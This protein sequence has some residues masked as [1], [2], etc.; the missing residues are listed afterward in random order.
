MRYYPSLKIIEFTPVEYALISIVVGLTIGSL[1]KILLIKLAPELAKKLTICPQK[2]KIL[3]PVQSTAENPTETNKNSSLPYFN[4][5]GG[6]QEPAYNDYIEIDMNEDFWL[7]VLEINKNSN[8]LRRIKKI[9]QISQRS[10]QVGK[11]S[12]MVYFLI[13]KI[14]E[15][16]GADKAI[17]L[18][19]QKTRQ[20]VSNYLKLYSEKKVI[21]KSKKELISKIRQILQHHLS[22]KQVVGMTPALFA[23][24]LELDTNYIN[25]AAWRQFRSNLIS[26]VM[27]TTVA[28]QRLSILSIGIA[29][30]TYGGNLRL[31][32]HAL[33]ASSVL[34]LVFQTL[35]HTEICT[36]NF[37]PI[38]PRSIEQI[39]LK[40]ESILTTAY[41]IENTPLIF[42]NRE[43]DQ[44]SP[45]LALALASDKEKPAIITKEKISNTLAKSYTYL[46][47]DKLESPEITV[48]GLNWY[49]NKLATLDYTNCNALETIIS[50]YE[51]IQFQD[52]EL[53]VLKESI[54]KCRKLFQ[55]TK[56]GEQKKSQEII[57]KQ[58]FD[59]TSNR[60]PRVL[61]QRKFNRQV[62]TLND[63]SSEN[64]KAVNFAEIKNIPDQE[65]QLKE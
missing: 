7:K 34:L 16:P 21:I 61:K 46:S 64:P 13:E 8:V 37:L 26:S 20:P 28:E 59:Q 9:S 51:M 5:R 42:N 65:S 31:M 56:S 22:L 23:F 39:T 58:S 6:N 48:L 43:M 3:D 12:E 50:K 32:L 35:I 47:S 19:Q 45:I 25:F 11:V 15:Q 27:N 52:S 60:N 41:E 24:L 54:E 10:R 4:S 1:L 33:G 40:G 17:L 30:V 14:G 63:L 38:R 55:A 2:E 53:P 18:L 49:F 57:V 44:K 29:F 62:H 36:N